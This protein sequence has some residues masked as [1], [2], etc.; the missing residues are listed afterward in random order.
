MAAFIL[1]EDR[2]RSW[3][4]LF[5]QRAIR[6]RSGKENGNVSAVNFLK[7]ITG[8]LPGELPNRI[9]LEIDGRSVPVELRRHARARRFILRVDPKS[10][11]VRLTVPSGGSQRQA[12]QFAEKQKHW[13]RTRLDRLPDIVPFADGVEIPYQGEVHRIAHRPGPG[14]VVWIDKASNGQPPLICVA[15]AKAHLPRRLRDWLK[16]EAEREISHYVW[17]YAKDLGVTVK[18]VSIRDQSSRW[19]SCSA[20]GVLSF[21][22]RIVLAPEFVLHYLAAHEVAHLREMNHSV[23]FWEHTN[24]LCADT[25]QAK[26]WLNA[27]GRDLHGIGG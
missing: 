23:R 24:A 27:H 21:S 19:G 8:V 16:Q 25:E 12:A 22:W 17:K 20:T 3:H 6:S 1:R 15:G 4:N 2:A 11:A 13:I 5:L 14:R 7:A 10:R 18:R 26:A 9:E